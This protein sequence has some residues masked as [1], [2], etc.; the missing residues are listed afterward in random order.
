MKKNIPILTLILLFGSLITSCKN[1]PKDPTVIYEVSSIRKDID[2]SFRDGKGQ[3]IQKKIKTEVWTTFF[4]GQKGDTVSLA[5]KSNNL[6]D[7]IE[8]KII[9]DGNVLTSTVTN[10]QKSG[11]NITAELSTIIPY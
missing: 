5:I 3:N 10:G 1:E 7:Q 2:I 4:Q 6:N 8:A 9:Y 11:Q